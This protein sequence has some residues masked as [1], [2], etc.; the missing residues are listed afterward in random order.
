M[1]QMLSVITY[2]PQWPLRAARMMAWESPSAS[3]YSWHTS[4]SSENSEWWSRTC[5]DHH[6][7]L[8]S[9]MS[10]CM[11]LGILYL[12][13]CIHYLLVYSTDAEVYIVQVIYRESKMEPNGTVGNELY[14]QFSWDACH[15]TNILLQCQKSASEKLYAQLSPENQTRAPRLY[16]SQSVYFV[17][18][19][20]KFITF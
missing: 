20:V 7:P 19:Q 2:W 8:S 17:P 13:T 1:W 11:C 16:C 10:G 4:V 18:R 14:F 15:A 12:Y 6:G 3:A 5:S 9:E